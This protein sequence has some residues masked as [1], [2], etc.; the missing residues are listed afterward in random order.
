MSMTF[1][2]TVIRCGFAFLDDIFAQHL[3]HKTVLSMLAWVIF[4]FLLWG[5]YT[6]GWRGKKAI[7]LSLGGFV[8][9]MLSY[10]GSKFVSEL[11]LQL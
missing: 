2:P 7:K 11:I 4:A 5:R 10:F 1:P 3:V 6:Y 9:L 8:F